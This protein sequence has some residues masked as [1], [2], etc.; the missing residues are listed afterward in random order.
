[1]FLLT[2]HTY[3]LVYS[4]WNEYLHIGFQVVTEHHTFFAFKSLKGHLHDAKKQIIYVFY[5]KHHP[6]ISPISPYTMEGESMFP[7]LKHYVI[8]QF[9]YMQNYIMFRDGGLFHCRQFPLNSHYG[10][11]V[12]LLWTTL[13]EQTY[14]HN[15]RLI[16]TLLQGHMC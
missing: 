15:Q 5:I 1:M 9:V 4:N 16:G 3:S 14:G 13:L 6:R 7:K 12:I 11:T 10:A 2:F 8:G